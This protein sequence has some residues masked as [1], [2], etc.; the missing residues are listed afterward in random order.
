MSGESKGRARSGRRPRAVTRRLGGIALLIPLLSALST[1]AIPLGFRILLVAL[2]VTAIARP[3]WAIT[4]VI[5]IVPFASW[6]F[7]AFDAPPVRSAEALVLVVLSGAIIAA[8]RPPRTPLEGQRPALGPAAGVFSA[9]TCASAA[10][11]LQVM[12]AGTHAPWPFLRDVLVFLTRDYLVGPPGSFAGVADAALLL[13]G[14]GLAFLVARHARD[15]VARPAQLFAAIGL[16]G[17]LAA[18]LTLTTFVTTALEAASVREFF[19]RLAF[20]RM[21]VHVADAN[22]AGSFFAMT[23]W[24]ALAFAANRRHPRAPRRLALGHGLWLSAAAL[25]LSAMWITGSRMAVLAVIGTLGVVAMTV[26]G[27]WR[28]SA[29]LGTARRLWLARAPKRAMAGAIVAGALLLAALAIGLDPRPSPARSTSRMLSMRADFMVTGLRM[30]ASA[31]IFGVGVGR[32]FEMSGRF[33]PPSIYWFY[34]HENAH[35]N[36]LQIGG[37]LGLA[38]LAAFVWL[39][40]VAAIRIVRGA[41]AD[42]G[43][44]LLVG[45][46]AGLGAFVATWMTS[47]PMLVAEVAYPFW[48]LLGVALARAD[49]NAQ[50]PLASPD[51]PSRAASI[52]GRPFRGAHVLVGAVIAVLA[53]SVPVRAKRQMAT[54][55][56]RRFSFGFY[57]WEQEDG[58]RFRWTSRRATFFIPLNA[59][60]LRLPVSAIHVGSN[61]APTDVSIAIGGRVFHRLRLPND[62]WVNVRMRLPLLPEDEAFQRIDIITEPTWSP[63]ALFGGRSDVRVLGVQVGEPVTG[64]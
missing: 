42:P 41:G 6:L 5:V 20:S 46:L 55:D 62:E 27:P 43:D 1:P 52:A 13:E 31:P 60:E 40:A 49:G 64:P 57:D 17:A 36:F 25:I 58:Q 18:A 23:A 12:Q 21:T 38:G 45:A 28:K 15:G 56:F 39:L 35:N 30:M 8:A 22:A 53:V 29:V 24:V 54:I 59:R 51:V 44:R 37:E 7:V 4:A 11:M 3:D 61:L 50:P 16:A 47:H 32:Y 63:A 19:W 33:M 14:I 34:F 10:V 2:W 26:S 9:V 48:M